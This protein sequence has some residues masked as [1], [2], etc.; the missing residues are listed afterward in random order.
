MKKRFLLLSVFAA[1][2]L[3]TISC[4]NEKK[5]DEE[6]EIELIEEEEVEDDDDDEIAAIDYTKDMGKEPWVLNVE[7]ATKSN[8][9]YQVANWTGEYLQ[10]VFMSLKPGEIIELEVHKTHDQ[11]IRI[12]EGE[13][14][15]KM[16]KTKEN[17]D[18]NERVS[19][20]WAILVPANYWHTIENTGDEDLKIYTIYGPAEHE[21]GSMNKTF[22]DAQKAHHH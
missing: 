6:K 7:E 8:E 21:K 9:H 3:F 2:F 11:F 18:F 17:L 1:F 19:D 10:L 15:V 16:G 4:N 20:D 22:E 13:A 5:Q 12:E 14:I